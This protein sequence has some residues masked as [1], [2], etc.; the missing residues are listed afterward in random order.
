MLLSGSKNAPGSASAESFGISK[1]PP[2]F[3][4]LIAPVKFKK[5]I[6]T[7]MHPTNNGKQIKNETVYRGI[8]CLKVKVTSGKSVIGE[9]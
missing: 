2:I 8:L 3:S 4:G 7:P 6:I 9:I 5:Q 1:A